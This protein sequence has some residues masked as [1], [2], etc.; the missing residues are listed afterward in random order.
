MAKRLEHHESAGSRPARGAAICYAL[1]TMS[2]SAQPAGIDQGQDEGERAWTRFVPI[3]VVLVL[4]VLLVAVVAIGVALSR[5]SGPDV[6]S[7]T[8]ADLRA[9]P[10]GYDNR[11]VEITGSA[12]G[13]RKL[14]Y[15][16]QYALYTFRDDS[17][18]ILVLSRNGA[19]PH[20]GAQR[21]RLRAVYHSRVT[22]DDELKAIV[23][24]QLG[25]LAGTVVG[26]LL[27]GV[28]LDVVFLEH[29]SYEV[30]SDE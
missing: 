26:A 18:S 23:E 3:I 11:L 9:N 25:P 22:L 30:T 29:E 20:D 8:I 14:P 12:D 7:V 1:G 13:V 6:S 24:D 2:T 10:D 5:E 28:P 19:P 17:G 27:P 15:L 16:D 4:G 21:I